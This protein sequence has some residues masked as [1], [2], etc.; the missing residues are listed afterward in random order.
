MTINTETALRTYSQLQTPY[1][2]CEGLKLWQ[3]LGGSW[4][5]LT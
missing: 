2:P 4:S 3:E 1:M 5:G